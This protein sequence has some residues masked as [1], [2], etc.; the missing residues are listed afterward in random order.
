M[1]KGRWYPT[2]AML[3]DGRIAILAGWDEDG[4]AGRQPGSRGLHTGR[5]PRRARQDDTLR[6][7][8]AAGH[9]L[10]PASLHDA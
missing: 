6:E 4:H 1:G 9:E 3:A 2:Q 7:R 10:L 5:G 8:R